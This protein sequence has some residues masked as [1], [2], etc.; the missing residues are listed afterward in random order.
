MLSEREARARFAASRVARLATVAPS[1]A[2]HLVPITFAVEGDVV[3]T[4]VDHKPKTSPNLARL[5]NIAQNPR[6]AL[7]ADEYRDDWS[8]LWWARV[9]GEASVVTDAVSLQH[10]I[11]ALVARYEQYAERRP[12]GPVIVIRATRWSGWAA[13]EA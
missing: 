13:A 7:L 6:V 4:A 3:Y 1:G 12:T 10:P 5:R 2:P 8:Q 11:D 9:D